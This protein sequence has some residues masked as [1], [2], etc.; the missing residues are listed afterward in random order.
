MNLKIIIFIFFLIN[1][2]C[3]SW[4]TENKILFKVNNEIITSVDV[5]N[6]IE[7]LKMINKNLSELDRDQIFEIGKNSLIRE[8][9]KNYRIIKIF[10]NLEVEEKFYNLLLQDLLNKLNLNSM[11]KFENYIMSRGIKMGVVKKRFKL[12]FYGIS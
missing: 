8:K 10:E 7:Y 12:N 4:A 5:F 3:L 2:F 9:N 1:Q 11:Q 6:E